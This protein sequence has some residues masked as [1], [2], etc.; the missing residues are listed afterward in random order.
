[1]YSKTILFFTVSLT[2]LV[3]ISGVAGIARPSMYEAATFYWQVQT[4]WQDYTD[5]FFVVP[6]LL[7]SG[8]FASKGSSP[9]SA[10]WMGAVLY[11]C[12][13]YAIFAFTI[14]F[15]RSF[16]F[17]CVTLGLSFYA[18]LWF[19]HVRSKSIV[20]RNDAWWLGIYLILTGCLFFM[21]WLADVLPG[22]LQGTAPVSVEK[23]GLFTNPVH[24]LD[25]S[26]LLPGYII[27]GILLLRRH[28]LACLT[29]AMLLS[30]GALMG[31]SIAVLQIVLFANR[32]VE[33]TF[34]AFPML[35]IAAVNVIFLARHF[36]A[37]ERLVRNKKA[38]RVQ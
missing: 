30:F 16:L 22:L 37:G 28:R 6:V 23:A 13:T 4:V 17:Y 20:M 14:H 21:V 2:T 25:I 12:Y 5:V 3:V 33:S 15:N 34:V 29:A 36:Y 8:M 27:S 38:I 32:M 19:F 18:L 10:V 7:W 26:L 11:L 24:V 31:V 35:V 1:M 9:G